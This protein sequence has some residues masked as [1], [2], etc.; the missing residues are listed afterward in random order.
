[1]SISEVSDLLDAPE[2]LDGLDEGLTDDLIG[3]A[4]EDSSL[5]DAALGDVSAGEKDPLALTPVEE[6]ETGDS[7]VQDETNDSL[8]VEEDPVCGNSN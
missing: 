2:G 8:Q 5:L 7:L 4:D 6:T 1:M 3:D